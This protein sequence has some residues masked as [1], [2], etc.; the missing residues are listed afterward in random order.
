MTGSTPALV[1]P[2]P[3]AVTVQRFALRR[4]LFALRGVREPIRAVVTQTTW[5]LKSET[6]DS[7]MRQ[8]EHVT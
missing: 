4:L 8:T 3:E 7:Q 5:A 6:R 1:S 2:S